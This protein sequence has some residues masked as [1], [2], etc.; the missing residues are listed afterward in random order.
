V[1]AVGLVA[2]EPARDVLRSLLCLRWLKVTEHV[3]LHRHRDRLLGGFLSSET[4][5]EKSG[6]VRSKYRQPRSQ[7][8]RRLGAL[9][10]RTFELVKDRLSWSGSR[11]V[12]GDK[13]ELGVDRA[14]LGMAAHED[15]IAA[16]RHHCRGRHGR[17]R[18]H[19]SDGVE[20]LISEVAHDCLSR[21]RH[22]LR[23]YAV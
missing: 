13:R 12:R 17:N 20:P 3:V 5:T 14:Q 23:D 1:T 9:L 6:S 19:G 18:N 4:F 8:L 10:F 15:L 11:P 21:R 22:R 2:V 7:R 16:E